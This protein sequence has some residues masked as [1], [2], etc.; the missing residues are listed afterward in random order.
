MKRRSPR[1]TPRELV[2]R[3]HFPHMLNQHG[4]WLQPDCASF[5]RLCQYAQR[6]RR[7]GMPDRVIASLFTDLYWDAVAEYVLNAR[8]R[9]DGRPAR[10]PA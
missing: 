1:Q 8:Q 10:P 6:L 4:Q 2:S 9:R 7:L 5:N 3:I